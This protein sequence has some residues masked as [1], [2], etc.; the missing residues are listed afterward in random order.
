MLHVAWLH[1]I[2][3]QSHFLCVAVAMLNVS[4]R[5]PS[6]LIIKKKVFFFFFV[7]LIGRFPLFYLPGLLCV[8]LYH[9]VCCLLIYFCSVVFISF[10]YPSV[11]FL[12][13]FS[14]FWSKIPPVF[15]YPV[16][17]QLPLLLPMLWIL[18][19]ET[20]FF[21]FLTV[22]S[23]RPPTGFSLALWVEAHSSAFSFCSAFPASVRFSAGVACGGL[24]G[25]SLWEPPYTVSGPTGFGGRVG[26]D[27]NT[28]H[29][30]V[31]M[32]WYSRR[33]R[34]W[35]RRSGEGQI[36]LVSDCPCSAGAGA[37]PSLLSQKPWG[38]ASA[39]S[40]PCKCALFAFPASAPLLRRGGVWELG[41][42]WRSVPGPR[43][44]GCVQRSRLPLRCY[45]CNH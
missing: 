36:P 27:V 7:V 39:R 25:V 43:C 10:L 24:K 37:G 4:L 32:C 30:F 31:G 16:P 18:Y 28:S 2:H 23:A 33:G 15:I 13:I 44:S 5:I 38:L 26:F 1:Q 45:P 19:R 9:L 14:S 42:W 8:L 34:R 35:G 21:C 40:G 11:W 41:V 22:S 3:L 17:M 6:A 12:F 20:V 29:T